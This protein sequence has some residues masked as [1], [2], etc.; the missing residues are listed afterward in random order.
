MLYDM[1]LA[2]MLNSELLLDRSLKKEWDLGFEVL[3]ALVQ[4]LLPVDISKVLAGVVTDKK[5]WLECK[6][7]RR[8]LVMIG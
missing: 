1:L 6:R 4:V 8:T 7:L 3:H 5:R 2:E